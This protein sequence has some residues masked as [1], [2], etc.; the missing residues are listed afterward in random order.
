MK[1][2]II[3]QTKAESQNGQNIF[4][5]QNKGKGPPG[6]IRSPGAGV[7]RKPDYELTMNNNIKTYQKTDFQYF[8]NYQ[9]SNFYSHN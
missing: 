8:N 2:Q 7:C 1:K 5:I 6:R 9:F 4:L 3:I